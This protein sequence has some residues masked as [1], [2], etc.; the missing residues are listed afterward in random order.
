HRGLERHRFRS[1][2]ITKLRP[3]FF[4]EHERTIY[5]PALQPDKRFDPLAVDRAL[6]VATGGQLDK[7]LKLWQPVTTDQG[8]ISAEGQAQAKVEYAKAEEVLC[9]AA[10]KVFGIPAFPEATDAVAL[11]VLVDYL[12]WMQGK[13][14]RGETPPTSSQPSDELL[15]IVR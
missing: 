9:A 13:G 6:V 10:R 12:R 2:I 1:Q 7:L 8:D 15:S 14:S 11:E 5:S 4:E 3:M